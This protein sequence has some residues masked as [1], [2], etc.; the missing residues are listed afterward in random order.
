MSDL[1]RRQLEAQIEQQEAAFNQLQAGYQ[2]LQNMICF[3]VQKFGNPVILT[4]RDLTSMP[5]AGRLLVT[6]DA[7]TNSITITFEAE[8]S[9]DSGPSGHK[10]T[11]GV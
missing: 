7:K 5:S 1:E 4:E 6:T 8:T 3:M 10:D 9:V 2:D 11:T